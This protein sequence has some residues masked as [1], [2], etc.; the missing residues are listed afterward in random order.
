MSTRARRT[1]QATVADVGKSG[2]EFAIAE[3]EAL[4][5]A[6]PSLACNGLCGHS[7]SSH[8]DASA[9]ERERI[10]AARVDLDA[11]TVD[12]ACPALSRAL[13]ASGRCT[14]YAVRPMVCRL[15]GTAASMP[16][17]HGCA[18][19]DGVRG[20]REVLGALMA[21][22]EV[23]GHRDAGVREVMQACLA[24]E[25]ASALLAALLR[26]QREVKPALAARLRALRAA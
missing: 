12:G 11:A 9:L 2:S 26:G 8:V 17:P 24:D 25:E 15:W 5:A 1:R 13:V 14:V 6:L 19:E 4:Y 3:L 20:D 23:S 22:L 10:A 21:S 7:C 18:P 16:C